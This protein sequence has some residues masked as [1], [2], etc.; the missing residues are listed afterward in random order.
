MDD[1]SSFAQLFIGTKTL[2][3]DV[4]G[5]KTYKQFFNTLED[6]I[7]KRGAIDKLM[8]DS[9]QSNTSNVVKDTLSALFIDDWQH[10]LKIRQYDEI[11]YTRLK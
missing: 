5:M 6:N 1:G 9:A 3:I 11:K 4:Y 8:S 2:A 7:R 10:V